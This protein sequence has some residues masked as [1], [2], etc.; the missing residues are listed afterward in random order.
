MGGVPNKGLQLWETPGHVVSGNCVAAVSSGRGAASATRVMPDA[1]ERK[2]A[3][4][5]S[6]FSTRQT[7]GGSARI[8]SMCWSLTGQPTQRT[9]HE[10]LS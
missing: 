1:N 10:R 6:A 7:S 9:F 3:S 2:D 5:C 8:S 4:S